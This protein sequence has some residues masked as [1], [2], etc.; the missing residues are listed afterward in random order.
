[1]I[2]KQRILYVVSPCIRHNGVDTSFTLRSE[3]AAEYEA[4]YQGMGRVAEEPLAALDGFS[5][6]LLQRKQWHRHD[7]LAGLDL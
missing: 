7:M 2:V 1:M 5:H 6:T 3:L 4:V